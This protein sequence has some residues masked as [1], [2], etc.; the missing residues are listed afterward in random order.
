MEAKKLPPPLPL[1]FLMSKKALVRVGSYNFESQ[2][3]TDWSNLV[4]VHVI[5]D[6]ALVDIFSFENVT[7]VLNFIAVEAYFD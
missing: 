5:V 4:A 3:N 6:I 1:V 2:Q 7:L